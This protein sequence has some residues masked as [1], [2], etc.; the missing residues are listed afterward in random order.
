RIDSRQ[1]PDMRPSVLLQLDGEALD[2]DGLAAFA[3]LFVSDKGTNRFAD[4]DL[5]FEIKAGPVT[6]GGLTA[7]TV[8]T[9]LRLR[10]GLLEIDRLSI[11]GLAGASLSATGRIKDFPQSPTGNFDASI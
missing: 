8:D 5:D 10:N 1:P 2:V 4:R 9:A 11:G 7:E 3:S 6:A